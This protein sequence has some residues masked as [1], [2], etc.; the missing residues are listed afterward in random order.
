M[1]ASLLLIL[2]AAL[3]CVNGQLT[4]TA[5]VSASAREDGSW[6]ENG[7]HYQIYDITASNSGTQTIFSLFAL[8]GFP[9]GNS[10]AQAWNYEPSSGA[11]LNFG[12]SLLPGQSFTGAGF[13]LA[14]PDTPTLAFVTPS[15]MSGPPPT[16][17]P[18]SAPTLPPTSAPTNPPGTCQASIAVNK[19]TATTGSFNEWIDGVQYPSQIWDT[20][21]T[22]TGSRSIH[23]IT[24][25]ITPAGSTFVNQ[26]NKWNLQYNSN[27]QTYSVDLFAA[28]SLPNSQYHGAGFVIAG[29][30][31]LAP[32][33]QIL[34][35][36][37][38]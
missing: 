28:L 1:K 37:C 22:N 18:T 3:L 7:V 36:G 38:N 21:F 9:A 25:S 33:V 8:Y 24:I 35:V 14:G 19:R 20:V 29:A 31:D 34:S 15:C 30:T 4:C 16:N 13:T 5:Q 26:N 6:Q 11:V 10:I 23:S 2:C 32:H 27:A 12:G 17:P